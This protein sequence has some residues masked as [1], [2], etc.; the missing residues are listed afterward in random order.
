M[1]VSLVIRVISA[2]AK[3]GTSWVDL[4]FLTEEPL[5]RRLGRQ[6]Y[7]SNVD[8]TPGSTDLRLSGS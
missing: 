2:L 5:Y 1:N 7:H 8:K 3:I 4:T 6:G